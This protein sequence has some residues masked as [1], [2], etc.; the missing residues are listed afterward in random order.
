MLDR[1]VVRLKQD[2]VKEIAYLDYKW[3]HIGPGKYKFSIMLKMNGFMSWV[4]KRSL[5]WVVYFE[6]ENGR[7]LLKSGRGKL[8]FNEKESR[9]EVE[10]IKGKQN[11]LARIEMDDD[12]GMRLKFSEMVVK[13]EEGGMFFFTMSFH[14]LSFDFGLDFIELRKLSS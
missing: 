8:F 2:K 12:K 7:N 1:R 10:E 6:N 5:S 13:D 4:A 9:M 3:N 11:N 14:N